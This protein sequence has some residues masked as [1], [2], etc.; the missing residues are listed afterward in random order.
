M[1][2]WRRLIRDIFTPPI[3]QYDLR[4]THP[5]Q[6]SNILNYFRFC[7]CRLIRHRVAP[8]QNLPEKGAWG[9]WVGDEIIAT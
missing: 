1:P 8:K 5:A 2:S 9:Y 6:R 7:L 4:Q 3:I